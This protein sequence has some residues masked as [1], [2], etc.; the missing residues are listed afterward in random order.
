MDFWLLIIGILLK[1][2]I[3]FVVL[4]VIE[5]VLGSEGEISMSLIIILIIGVFLK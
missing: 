5:Y 2:I 3:V 1:S 4:F